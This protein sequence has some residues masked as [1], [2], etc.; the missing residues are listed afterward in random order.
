MS[1]DTGNVNVSIPREELPKVLEIVVNGGS[2]ADIYRAGIRNTKGRAVSKRQ[3]RRYRAEA[4]RIIEEL[5]D[6]TLSKFL[7]DSY[8][9]DEVFVDEDTA[10]PP[11]VAP[12]VD[13]RTAVFDIEVL[14]PSF[15]MM[16]KFSHFL[17]CASFFPL[18]EEEPYTLELEFDDQRDDRRLLREVI[19]ELSKYQFIIG[20]NVK[21]YDINW[22]MTRVMFYGWSKP[23]RLFYYDTYS[24]LRRVPLLHKKSLGDSIDFF[25]IHDAEK[26][27]IMPVEWDR[28]RS[29]HEKDFE[30]AM[31]DIVYHCEE[32]V[33]ANRSLYDI[34]IGLDYDPKPSWKLWFN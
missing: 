25:R 18:D 6:E 4:E 5:D 17:L 8:M 20:H 19:N 7:D 12:R 32:D 2:G 10:Y 29:P 15:N 30:K 28:I 24:A 13:N 11:V 1:F 26:T 14:S 16:G 34:L 22:L 27:K 9:P 3:G 21:R 23:N 31:E 33:I